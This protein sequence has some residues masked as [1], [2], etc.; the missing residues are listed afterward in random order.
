VGRTVMEEGADGAAL[1]L[2]F[3]QRTRM[4]KPS[5]LPVLSGLEGGVSTGDSEGTRKKSN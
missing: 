1:G 2:L 5:A 3:A 4:T